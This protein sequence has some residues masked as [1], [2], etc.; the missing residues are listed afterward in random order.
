M[1]KSNRENQNKE[2][3]IK[4]RRTS[5]KELSKDKILIIPPHK[6]YI[7]WILSTLVDIKITDQNVIETMKGKSNEGQR[8]TGFKLIIKGELR[9]R[10]EYVADEPAQTVH[11]VNFIIPFSTYIVLPIDY[12]RKTPIKV[13]Y[14]I[15][16]VYTRS[17]SKE[18]IFN[19]ITFRIWVK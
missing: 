14:E 7:K 19:T 12:I 18:C 1:V 4:N 15:E 13:E 10:I 3:K 6:P 17:I 8:L 16:D 9:E 5:F 2:I 11:L